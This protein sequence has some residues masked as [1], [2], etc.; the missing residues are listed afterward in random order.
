MNMPLPERTNSSVDDDSVVYVSKKVCYTT[1]LDAEIQDIITMVMKNNL[2]FN[3]VDGLGQLNCVRQALKPFNI[4][5]NRHTARNFVMR[6]AQQ[7]Y[8]LIKK[9]IKDDYP[10]VCFDSASRFGR[11]VFGISLRYISNGHIKDHTIGML[12]QN[13]RQT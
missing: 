3:A 8:K 9:E 11:N 7:I 5:L 4:V 13:Y 10:S 1:N 2:L 6:T 12:T